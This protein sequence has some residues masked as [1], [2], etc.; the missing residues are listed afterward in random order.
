MATCSSILAWEIPWTEE[1]GIATAH[2]V[3]KSWMQLNDSTT[4]TTILGLGMA[5]PQWGVTYRNS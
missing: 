3:A 5:F 4:A 1:P 2:G